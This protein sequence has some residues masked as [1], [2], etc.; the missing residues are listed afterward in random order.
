MK[1]K[2]KNGE[3]RERERKSKKIHSEQISWPSYIYIVHGHASGMD[4]HYYYM[5]SRCFDINGGGGCCCFYRIRDIILSLLLFLLLA[6]GSMEQYTTGQSSFFFL[7]EGKEIRK[8][9]W[10]RN[11]DMVSRNFY[12]ILFL[13]HEK[14]YFLWLNEIVWGSFDQSQLVRD[15]ELNYRIDGHRRIQSKSWNVEA[16]TFGMK[17]RVRSPLSDWIPGT[18]S[19]SNVNFYSSTHQLLFRRPKGRE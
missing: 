16:T 14:S 3:R 1:V 7:S 19:Y 10:Q 2:K 8:K 11:I 6:N 13:P 12:L 17:S 4:A 18:A 15:G 5:P 9:N